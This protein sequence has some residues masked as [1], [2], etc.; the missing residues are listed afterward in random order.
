MRGTVGPIVIA[1]DCFDGNTRAVYVGH[2]DHGLY[3]SYNTCM[4]TYGPPL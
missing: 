1:S 2:D 3:S 4:F